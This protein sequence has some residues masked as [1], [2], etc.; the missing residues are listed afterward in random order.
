MKTLP[1][2]YFSFTYN[3]GDLSSGLR[4]SSKLPRNNKSLT[5]CNGAVGNEGTL[6]TLDTVTISSMVDGSTELDNFPFPQLF[7]TD[8]HIIVCNETSIQTLVGSI[9]VV[10]L[11]GLPAGDMWSAVGV[12]DFIYLSNGVVS[13]VRDPITQ[14]YSIDTTA[15]KSSALC[16]YNGQIIVGYPR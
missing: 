10:Q 2:G 15:P 11:T 6:C 7:V 3:T 8:R 16:N 12:H 5:V 4:S 14:T 13:V 1:T 9:L